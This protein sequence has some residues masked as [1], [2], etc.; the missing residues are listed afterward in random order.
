MSAVASSTFSAGE[1]LA[2]IPADDAFVVQLACE[3][4]HAL[5]KERFEHSGG[6]KTTTA[7]RFRLSE[8]GKATQPKWLPRWD[9]WTCRNIAGAGGL[10][11]LKHVRGQGCVWD[12]FTCWYAAEGGHLGTSRHAV[13]RQ[14][15]ATSSS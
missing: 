15:E 3:P 2:E 1:I 4:L 12:D 13:Q 10:E 11:V 14:K 5:V 9:A 6:V 8:A 7:G